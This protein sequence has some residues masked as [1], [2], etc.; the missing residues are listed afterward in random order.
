MALKLIRRS[1]FGWP[2]R[3]SAGTGPCTN[4]IVVHYDGSKLGLADKKHASC[5]TYWK[6][7][8]SFHM[9]SARGWSDIGYSFGVCPH[10][11]AFEGRGFGVQQAAQPGGNSTWT[12]CTFMTGDGEQPTA[13]QIQAFRDLR[14]WLATKGLRSAVKGHRNFIS[15]SCPGGV[16]YALVTNT[17]SALYKGGS[18]A[19]SRTETLVKELPVV[20]LGDKGEDVQSVQALLQ[21][22]S[23]PEVKMTGT[24]DTVT[25]QAV[26]ALQR[27]GK[28]EDDGI[29]GPADTWP[30][31][32]RLKT[33]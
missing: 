2:T 14:S 25:E 3:V 22:R 6:N 31:L 1:S 9:G 26:K 20:K 4:G 29:V 5:I 7:T 10:G 33:S 23:H 12:S 15:T 18:A 28:V 21:A 11:Y 30:L 19:V 32:L 24:F 16:L 8:R 17:S 13:L 27:W